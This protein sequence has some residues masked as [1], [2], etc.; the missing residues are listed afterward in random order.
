MKRIGVF[1]AT[2]EG[3]TQLIAERVAAHLRAR[4]FDAA[5]GKLRGH[6]ANASLDGLWAAVLAASVHGGKHEPE[7]VKFVRSHL[8]EL[9]RRRT[10]FLSVMLSEAG[11][12]RSE[13]IPE[14]RA[15]CKADVQTMI[16]N[17]FKET[18]G[19][20]MWSWRWPERCCTANTNSW[21]G[22]S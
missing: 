3:H 7:M 6:A 14:E 15:Q 19:G 13:S 8:G 20:R 16:E 9:N 10:A 1:Y 21:F 2:R 5:A 11:V 12:E 22:S 18:G 17:F 4:G